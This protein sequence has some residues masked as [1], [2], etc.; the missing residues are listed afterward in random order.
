M[1]FQA[2]RLR[3]FV[4]AAQSANVAY[5]AARRALFDLFVAAID[6]NGEVDIESSTVIT[7]RTFLSNRDNA[8]SPDS[9]LAYEV[10]IMAV[11]ELVG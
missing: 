6:R 2:D 4:D 8:P 7:I 1:R 3:T 10:A 5:Y 11:S 9:R